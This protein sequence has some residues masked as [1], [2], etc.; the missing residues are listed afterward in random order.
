MANLHTGVV[1]RNRVSGRTAK[2]QGTVSRRDE[3]YTRDSVYVFFNARTF[4]FF[5]VE[6]RVSYVYVC[7]V[8]RTVISRAELRDSE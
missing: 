3:R 7:D 2:L 8:A 1:T 4:F 5:L 6:A